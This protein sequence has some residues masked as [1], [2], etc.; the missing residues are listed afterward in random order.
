MSIDMVIDVLWLFEQCEWKWDEK[1]SKGAKLE[2]DV[3]NVNMRRMEG[4]KWKGKC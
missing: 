1:W 2:E 4:M 3:V